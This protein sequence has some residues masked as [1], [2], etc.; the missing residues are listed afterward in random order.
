MTY[1]YLR[2]VGP[3]GS[4]ACCC[5]NGITQARFISGRCLQWHQL[6]GHPPLLVV[7][8]QAPASGNAVGI[9]KADAPTGGCTTAAVTEAD[10]VLAVVLGVIA[11]TANT[12]HAMQVCGA[13]TCRCMTLD[14]L[15]AA[16]AVGM[17]LLPSTIPSSKPDV[18]Y[19][20][21]LQQ[22]TSRRRGLRHHRW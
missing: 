2:Y 16:C 19:Q 21:S 12:T 8:S 14:G 4:T 13:V 15:G 7:S 11:R 6:P 3:A 22:C 20:Q 5:L 17:L 9:V 18:I 10:V 1:R